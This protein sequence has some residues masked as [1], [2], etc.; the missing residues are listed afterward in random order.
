MVPDW[1]KCRTKLEQ[2]ARRLIEE[3]K[4]FENQKGLNHVVSAT[5]NGTMVSLPGR[6]R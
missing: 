2:T 1:N 4:A 3:R 5:D 6:R